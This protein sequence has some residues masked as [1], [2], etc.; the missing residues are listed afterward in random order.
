MHRKNYF[1]RT[2]FL[3]LVL[4]THV[5]LLAQTPD[6]NLLDRAVLQIGRSIYTQKEIEWYALCKLLL[7]PEVPNFNEF[8]T[9][10]RSR[11]TNYLQMIEPDLVMLDDA[12][13]LNVFVPPDDMQARA[14]DFIYDRINHDQK[15]ASWVQGADL[16]DTGIRQNIER[17]LQIEGYKQSKERYGQAAAG[18]D[19]KDSPKSAPSKQTENAWYGEILAKTQLK[20]FQDAFVY[21]SLKKITF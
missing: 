8:A 7:N 21:R 17:L 12:Q 4:T 10:I 11:W 6:A 13:R 5:E 15:F 14:R 3:F 16:D 18:Q 2:I 1:R 20:Y 19:A 9:E